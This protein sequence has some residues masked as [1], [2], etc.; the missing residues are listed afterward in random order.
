MATPTAA[1]SAP[2]SAPPAAA[3]PPGGAAARADLRLK[4]QA[5]LDTVL[6]GGGGGGGARPRQDFFEPRRGG[7]GDGTPFF[8]GAGT[9]RG[10]PRTSTFVR[11]RGVAAMV[12]PDLLAMGTFIEHAR[13]LGVLAL[14]GVTTAAQLVLAKR[15]VAVLPGAPLLLLL[16]HLRPTAALCRAAAQHALVDAEPPTLRVRLI[17]TSVW[18][19]SMLCPRRAPRPGKSKGFDAPTLPPALPRSA[20]SCACPTR[21][22]TPRCL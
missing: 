8:A 6:K 20:R 13:A 14:F 11:N 3:P 1:S 18:P 4:G 17:E 15:S 5:Y 22:R 21:W 12:D 19:L 10:T 2:G 16:L 7:I 9:P